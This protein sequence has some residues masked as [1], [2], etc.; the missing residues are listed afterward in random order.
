MSPKFHS[1]VTYRSRGRTPASGSSISA[2]N[3][4][5][6]P[7]NFRIIAPNSL[8]ST[9]V[10]LFFVAA[11]EHGRLQVADGFFISLNRLK[12]ILRRCDDT[13]EDDEIY[14]NYGQRRLNDFR[15]SF[16]SLEQSG[17]FRSIWDY[18]NLMYFW[19]EWMVHVWS[20][21][22]YFFRDVWLIF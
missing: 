10:C 18:S 6:K 5:R 12:G 16:T 17:W 2:E 4:R 11:S 7:F 9:T 22:V 8:S 14:W 13:V 20:P 3:E 19:I 21:K 15:G 1:L